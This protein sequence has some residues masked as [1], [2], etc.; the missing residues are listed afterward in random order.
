MIIRGKNPEDCVSSCD[1]VVLVDF[2][3][4]CLAIFCRHRFISIVDRNDV[5]K[6]YPMKE[7]YDNLQI[8]WFSNIM[9]KGKWSYPMCAITDTSYEYMDKWRFSSDLLEALNGVIK[10]PNERV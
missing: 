4:M 6:T 10:E 3:D 5:K 7:F 1:G 8:W 2:K 9:V